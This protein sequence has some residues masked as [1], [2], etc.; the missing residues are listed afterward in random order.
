MRE[1]TYIQALRE[2]MEEEMER[3]EK[4]FLIGEDIGPH[5]GVFGVTRGLLDKFGPKRVRQT[6]IS[7]VAIVGAACGSAMLGLRP[8]V[9]IMYFDFIM[10]AMDQ[11]V[12]QVAKTRYTSCGQI[13]LPMVIRT[14]SSANRGKGPHHSDNLEAWFFHTPGIKIAIPSTPFDAKGLLKSSIRDDSPVLF[15]ENANLYPTK[16]PVPDEEYTIPLGKAEVKK[17]G[18]DLTIV[19][20]SIQVLNALKAAHELE[21]IG[22]LAEVIDLRCLSPLDINIVVE[23]VKKTSKLLIVHEAYRRGGIGAEIAS[24]VTEKAFEYLDA[25]VERIGALE[26]PMP[27]A[28]S[29]EKEVLPDT[30]KIIDKARRLCNIN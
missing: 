14:P 18:R 8:V 16:G 10:I 27:F 9:E 21:S 17:E 13:K 22:I 23:S 3:D 4:V 24:L 29:L 28:E 19:A 6:P 30:S 1:I 12:N 15:I 20:T 5:G 2:A 7:E 25:P 11:V 26:V